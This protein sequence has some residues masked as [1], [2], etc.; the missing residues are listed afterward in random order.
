MQ[1][2][3]LM[4]RFTAKCVSLPGMR[5]KTNYGKVVQNEVDV[6]WVFLEVS[7]TE[8]PGSSTQ[9][10]AMAVETESEEEV[11]RAEV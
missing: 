7:V 2:K 9:H 1:T 8:A 6:K 5:K 11:A 3:E 10:A 4:N